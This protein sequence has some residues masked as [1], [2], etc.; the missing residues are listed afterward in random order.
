MTSLGVM[1]V[2]SADKEMNEQLAKYFS[3]DSSDQERAEILSWRGE[4]P[5]NAKAFLEAKEVWLESSSGHIAAPSAVLEDILKTHSIDTSRRSFGWLR[6]AAMIVAA[7]AMAV[8]FFT[9]ELRSGFDLPMASTYELEDGSKI[10]LHGESTFE[11]A[12][13]SDEQRKVILTG[14]AYFDIA[15]DEQ[16]PF[17]IQTEDAEIEVLGT[18]FV[19]DAYSPTGVT[20]VLVEEGKVSLAGKDNT[21]PLNIYLEQGDKGLL[22]E[23]SGLIRKDRIKNGNYLSWSNGLLSFMEAD[24]KEVA[25]VME[26]VYGWKIKLKNDKLNK[27]QLT[28][29]FNKK[30]PRE[31]VEIIAATFELRYEITGNQVTFSGK[32]C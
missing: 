16:R 5:E 29:R 9:M 10:I 3:G 27:C 23:S 13:M 25:T 26:D 11:L 1:P 30:T 32:G 15:R 4:S 18:S 14:K 20:E 6:Y 22:D 19:V 17:V 24:L 21:A 12:D 31:I 8:W 28:A 2:I 7:G